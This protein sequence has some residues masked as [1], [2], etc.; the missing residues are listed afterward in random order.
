MGASNGQGYLFGKAMPALQALQFLHGNA[1][2][3]GVGGR[4]VA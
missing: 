1:E 3:A 4:M 2:D